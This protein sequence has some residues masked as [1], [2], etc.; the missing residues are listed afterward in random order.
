MIDN[1]T[2]IS[3]LVLDASVAVKW[4]AEEENTSTAEVI[5]NKI[6]ERKITANAP[7]L[8]L[9]EVGNSLW[10]S[11]KFEIERIRA[12]MNSLFVSGLQF[13][14]LDEEL[15]QIAINLMIKY[16][17]TF[18]DAAYAALAQTLHIPLLTANPKDHKKIKEIEVMEL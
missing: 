2:K 9:Y 6:L 14:P 12:S 11:K 18:Y 16:D 17:L 3:N 10:K 1:D 5:F 15:S 13:C 7:D 4:F 8:I